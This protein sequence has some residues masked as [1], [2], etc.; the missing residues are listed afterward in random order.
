M[1]F[2]CPAWRFD[3]IDL[4][5]F[6]SWQSGQAAQAI[7]RAAIKTPATTADRQPSERNSFVIDHTS[8]RMANL[9]SDFV[10]HRHAD[11]CHRALL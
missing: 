5:S 2:V 10:F 1:I 11:T 8:R 6:A 9:A 7:I 4:P 3:W